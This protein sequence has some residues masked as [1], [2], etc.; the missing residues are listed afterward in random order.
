[1][2]FSQQDF[3][4][5]VTNHPII[6]QLIHAETVVWMN[7]NQ[8][9]VESANLSLTSED[10]FAAEQLLRRFQPYFEREFG[11]PLGQLGILESPLEEISDFQRAREY[12][13]NAKIPGNL[14]LKC[15]HDLPI[16]GSIKARGGF[17]EV[18]QYAE[19]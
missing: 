14:Y 12:S 6:Q 15:D 11:I 3:D 19:S 13:T 4:E 2:Y 1:M 18:L 5:L 7:P 17:Y 16:A 10:V 8:S 9:P